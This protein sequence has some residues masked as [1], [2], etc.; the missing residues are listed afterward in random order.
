MVEL[1]EENLWKGPKLRKPKP[2]LLMLA[3]VTALKSFLGT[4]EE[5]APEET[6]NPVNTR[7]AEAELNTWT[8]SFAWSQGQNLSLITE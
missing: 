2:R 1:V 8:F 7:T 5:E 6:K 3:E 4:T